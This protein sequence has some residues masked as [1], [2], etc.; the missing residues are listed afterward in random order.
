MKIATKSKTVVITL[1]YYHGGWNAG[2]G[3]D[4]FDD[5]ETDFPKG[6]HRRDGDWAIVSTDPDLA[7]L[8]EFW[9][10]EVRAAN[11]GKDGNALAGIR[12]GDREQGDEWILLVEEVMD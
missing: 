2:C 10:E 9:N 12:E 8:I 3:P 1:R 5:M 6:R 7:D 11:A 4:C